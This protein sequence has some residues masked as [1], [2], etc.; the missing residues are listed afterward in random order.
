MSPKIFAWELHAGKDKLDA[1][2]QAREVER[3]AI[4]VLLADMLGIIFRALG[5][6]VRTDEVGSMGTEGDAD[7]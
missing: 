6:V 4:Q 1:K 5:V 2:H 7:K 3:N